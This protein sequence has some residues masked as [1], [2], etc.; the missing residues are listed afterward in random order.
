MVTKLKENDIVSEL[1]KAGAHFAFVRAR[2]HPST[3][4]YIFGVKNRIEIFDL[5]KTNEALQKAL[6]YAKNLGSMN[7]T[8]LFVGGKGEAKNAIKA[9][10]MKLGMP[11][12][13]GRWIGGTLTNFSQI[14]RRVAK[15]EELTMQKEKGELAKYTKRERMLID[16]EIENLRHYFEGL[17][18]MKDLPKAMFV[19][20]PK[21]ESI[22]VTEAQD[23]GIPVVA[24]AGSDCDISALEYPVPANDASV[25]SITFFVNK[26][27]ES[28][29][30]GKT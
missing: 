1:F 19:V 29:N 10:A 14:K 22:A 2:R 25:A 21:K 26:F 17:T 20:D 18:S 4:P 11:Y 5:E 30:A 28:Y 27:V 3:K 24:L 9:G 8:V 13:D 16:K 12:V 6:E 23:K 15:L 7:A